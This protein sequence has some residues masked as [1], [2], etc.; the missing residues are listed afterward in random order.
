MLAV[1]S[2]TFQ[3]HALKTSVSSG[4]KKWEFL[5]ADVTEEND[6]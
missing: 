4:Y 2:Q 3:I 6:A 5:K 1:S